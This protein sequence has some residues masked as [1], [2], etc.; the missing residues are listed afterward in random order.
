MEFMDLGGIYL[1]LNRT[2]S[3]GSRDLLIQDR[4]M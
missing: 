4:S 3:H 2:K 1:R